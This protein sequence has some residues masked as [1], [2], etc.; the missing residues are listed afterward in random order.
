MVWQTAEGEIAV[1]GVF[2]DLDDGTGATTAAP[3][4][5]NL[6]RRRHS[7]HIRRQDSQ[8]APA[9][10]GSF[11]GISGF[12]TV[13]MVKQAGVSSNLLETVLSQVEEISSPGSVVK[14]QPLIMSELVDTLIG[15]SFQR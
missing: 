11:G 15:G 10:E 8:P 6:R 2:V 5:E 9:A 3:T 12:V 4:T 1:I 13:P 14:T 7:P